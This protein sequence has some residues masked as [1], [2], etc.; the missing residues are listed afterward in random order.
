M[1]L[2]KGFVLAE[3]K[4]CM[5]LRAV[6]LLVT[7][8]RSADGLISSR[9]ELGV[10][11]EGRTGFNRRDG[12]RAATET[13][14]GWEG[15]APAY[16]TVCQTWST[17]SEYC[18]YQREVDPAPTSYYPPFNI[19]QSRWVELQ[20][21]KEKQ[22]RV[23]KSG[24][25]SETPA[26]LSAMLSRYGLSTLVIGLI[27]YFDSHALKSRSNVSTHRKITDDGGRSF[28]MRGRGAEMRSMTQISTAFTD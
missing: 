8:Y 16:V 9:Q 19:A 6:M 2:G 15:G 10:C 4:V 5:L 23:D 20:L 7:R 14:G 12:K 18:P 27:S 24:V 22:K 17:F 26:Q 25:E 28:V 11:A 1:R 13:S 3:F 21:H